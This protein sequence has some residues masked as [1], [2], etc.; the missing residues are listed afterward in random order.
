M[1]VQ[2]DWTELA[3]VIAAAEQNG[4]VLGVAVVAPT[5]A[6]F[7][8]N[9]DR[10]FVA[11]STVKIAIMIELF[12]QIDRSERALSDRYRLRGEDRAAGSGVMLHLHDGMEFSVADLVYLMMSISDNTATN[13]LID[14]VGMARVNAT[15]RDLGMTTSTL[16]RRMQGRLAAPD[17]AEN[18]ATPRDY[19]GLIAALL[20]NRAASAGA[21]GQMLA[22]LETQQNDRRIARF[23]PSVGR[24]RWGSKTGS[25]PGGVVNDVGFVFTD[26]GPLIISVFCERP[27]NPHAGEEIIGEVSRAAL[28]VAA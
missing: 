23:L 22:M 21:C 12:R 28:A 13:V 4:A 16:G 18:W 17:E 20:E 11:A 15:M 10:H 8:H 2:N 27:A 9:A 14:R 5:G 6:A 3:R 25:L 1:V 19:A 24:P 26:R 7:A